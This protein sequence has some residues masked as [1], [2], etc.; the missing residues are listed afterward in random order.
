MGTTKK[1]T[2]KK[3]LTLS[4]TGESKDALKGMKNCREK[5][6]TLLDQQAI[7]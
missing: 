4:F 7:I 3:Y 2:E 5:S 1:V 6:G